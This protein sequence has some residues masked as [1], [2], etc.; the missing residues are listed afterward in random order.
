MAGSNR[1]A[2]MATESLATS[3]LII[4]SSRK[5]VCGFARNL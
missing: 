3:D 1:S 2:F 5:A 4:G